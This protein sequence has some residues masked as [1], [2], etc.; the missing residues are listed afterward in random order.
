MGKKKKKNKKDRSYSRIG[1]EI[2]VDAALV[3]AANLLDDASIMAHRT[4]NVEAMTEL[5]GAWSD[6]AV[7]MTAIYLD[8]RT[9]IEH[10][11]SRQT[12]AIGFAPPSVRE[13]MDDDD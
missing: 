6:L 12:Q 4:N 1:D 13:D 9:D 3:Q 8:T 10:N 2:S 11:G 5:S 7:K